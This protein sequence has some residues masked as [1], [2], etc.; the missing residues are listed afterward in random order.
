MVSF[1]NSRTFGLI[2]IE[3]YIEG[4]YTNLLKDLRFYKYL[5]CRCSVTYEPMYRFVG[6]QFMTEVHRTVGVIIHELKIHIQ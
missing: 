1:N 4:P 3:F 6:R 5:C 2:S